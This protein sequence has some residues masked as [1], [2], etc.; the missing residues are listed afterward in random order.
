MD[1]RVVEQRQYRATQY[2]EGGAPPCLRFGAW[3]MVTVLTLVLV[4]GVS[5]QD[6]KYPSRPIDVICPFG[7]GGGLD[8]MARQLTTLAQP[9]LGVALPVSNVPGASGNTGM[10]QLLA[11]KPDGYTLAAY[12][13][14]TFMTI[15][16]GLARHKVEDIEWLA[17]TQIAGSFLFVKSDSPFKTVQDLFRYAKENPGKLR[18]ASTGFGTPDDVTVRYL[19]KM[20]YPMTLVPYPKPGSVT[21]PFSGAT[22]KWC[23]S[24]RGT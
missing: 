5:A 13:Q 16:M 4:A 19:G 10:V 14:D 15:P 2:K 7:A 17:R 3:L 9:I 8:T 20:G 23:T 18:V 24:R 12:V 1:I 11:S 21:P 22:R 6:E